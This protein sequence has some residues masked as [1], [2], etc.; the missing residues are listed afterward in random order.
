MNLKLANFNVDQVTEQRRLIAGAEG[1]AGLIGTGTLDSTERSLSTLE[2]R[3]RSYLPT[4]E[5]N[6]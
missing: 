1:D 4:R 5:D 2:S 6:A 3:R